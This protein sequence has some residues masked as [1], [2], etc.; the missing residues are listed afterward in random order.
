MTQNILKFQYAQAFRPPTF[1]E[2]EYPGQGT[3]EASEIATFELGYILKRP[4]WE[5]RLILFHSDLTGPIS[6]DYAG[7]NGYINNPDAQLNGVELEYQQR[8]GARVKVDAN[9]SYVDATRTGTGA[10]LPGGTDL[11][12]NLALLWRVTD[13]WTAALQ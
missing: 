9:L 1:Y 13:D 12:G 10:T 3:L 7:L 11:L 5:G 6:F 8:L 2:L 4:S